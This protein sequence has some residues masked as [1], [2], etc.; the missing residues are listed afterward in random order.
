MWQCYAMQYN[1]VLLLIILQGWRTNLFSVDILFVCQCV[2]LYM[3]PFYALQ[4]DFHACNFHAWIQNYRSWRCDGGLAIVDIYW[5]FHSYDSLVL[6][7]IS[8]IV[9]AGTLTHERSNIQQLT[10]SLEG[11]DFS[12]IINDR[13]AHIL[14]FMVYNPIQSWASSTSSSIK[15]I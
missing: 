6:P 11:R 2:L 3:M 14:R 12:I 1:A 8:F 15:R 9:T 7:M 13:T 10:Q 5:Y 4:W